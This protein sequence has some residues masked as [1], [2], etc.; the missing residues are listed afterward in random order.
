MKFQIVQVVLGW[1]LPVVVA[2]IVYFVARE[3]LNIANRVDDLPPFVKRVAVTAI[4][5]TIVAIFQGLGLALPPECVALPDELPASC[6]DAINTPGVVK[7]VVA[8]LVAMLMHALK[9]S[10]PND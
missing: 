9:K 4:G 3:L 8:A 7:G 1:V 2:P 6:V 10:R 5:V